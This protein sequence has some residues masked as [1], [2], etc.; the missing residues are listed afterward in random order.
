MKVIVNNYL[1]L[2]MIY[3]YENIDTYTGKQKVTLCL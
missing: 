1:F 3:I 2:C